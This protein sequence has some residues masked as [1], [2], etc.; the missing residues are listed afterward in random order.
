VIVNVP[1][2]AVAA[3][4]EVDL[5]VRPCHNGQFILPKAT[6]LPALFTSSEHLLIS[7]RM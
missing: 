4:D 5:T 6:I 7:S 3:G 2:G 1:P